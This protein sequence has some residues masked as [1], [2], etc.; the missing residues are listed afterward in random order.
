MILEI[1]QIEV[2][3]GKEAAFEDGVA[4]AAHL[5]Q[6]ARGCLGMALHRSHEHPAR[7]RL[8]IEWETLEN[9]VVDFR[10]SDDF[11]A[12]RECIAGCVAGPPVVEHTY[13][14][15]KPF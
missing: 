15:L 7:Y 6:R 3:P 14:R 5:F 2:V 12:W 11:R 10:E 1:A 4:R 9:H 8:L 13:L